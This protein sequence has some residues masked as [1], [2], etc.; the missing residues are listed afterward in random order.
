MIPHSEQLTPMSK[1]IFVT[2]SR[3]DSAAVFSIVSQLQK[4]GYKVWIDQTGIDG[5]TFW[6]S[7]IVDAITNSAMVLFFASEA[8]CDSENVVKELALASEERKP[9]LPVFLEAAKLPPSIRY[10]I[11]GLQ[12]VAWYTDSKHALEQIGLAIQRHLNMDRPPE[13]PKKVLREEPEKHKS[14]VLIWTGSIF[15]FCVVGLIWFQWPKASPTQPS[16]LAITLN[17]STP[18]ST[19]SNPQA[20]SVDLRALII[21]NNSYKHITPLEN[22]IGDAKGMAD[23]LERKGFRVS[24]ITDGTQTEIMKAIELFFSDVAIQKTTR[25]LSILK[26]KNEQDIPK[27]IVFFLYYS[28]HAVEIDGVNYLIP[29]DAN[30]DKKINFSTDSIP[31][32]RLSPVEHG[33]KITNEISLFATGPS[34]VALDGSGTHSPFTSALLEHLRSSDE[35]ATAF[36]RVTKEVNE[37]TNGQQK[38]WMHSSLTV[39]LTLNNLQTNAPN[40]VTVITVLDSCRDNPTANSR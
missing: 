27:R 21:G 1:S 6:R 35:L 8:S 17:P 10:Q 39:P 26:T 15:S 32:T 9:I 14:K 28:G 16:N 29:I 12:H 33:F 5:A 38:P 24:I 7:A 19:P 4:D 13:S 36:T 20:E 18:E 34:S 30:I 37:I 25:G 3:R 31:L 40:G 2:Y 11:A 22:C 23:L